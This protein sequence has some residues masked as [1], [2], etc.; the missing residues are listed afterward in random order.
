MDRKASTLA[1]S[2]EG[3]AS[4]S[5]EDVTPL[6]IAYD[7]RQVTPGALFV[8][9]QGAHYDGH[10]FAAEAVR[11]GA[12]LLLCERPLATLSD[13]PQIIVA[14]SR[15][16][17][18]QVAAVF[19]GFP[20]Q[21]MRLIGVTGTNGKTTTTYLI[22]AMLESSGHKTGLIGTMTGSRT[23][24]ESPEIQSLLAGMLAGGCET[25]VME[26][27]S[28]GIDLHRTEG[29]VFSIGLFTNLTQDH[30]D[31]H[32][33]F[34]AYRDA[35]LRLFE[36]LTDVAIVND[37]DPNAPH[38]VAAAAAPVV[39]YGLH[40]READIVADNVRI[41]PTGVTYVARTPA[42]SFDV[43]LSLTG[44]FN[45]YNSLG[46]IAV[47]YHLGIPH[48]RMV[49][50]L[51]QVQVPGRF[52]R[53]D[54]GQP[55]SVIVDYAHTP[56]GLA[57]V[58]RTAREVASGRVIVVFGAG[59]D[60]DPTKRAPMGKAAAERAD[61]LIIT[62]DNPRSEEPQLICRDIEAGVM[63]VGL[64]PKQYD[65]ILPRREAIQQAIALADE[66][67]LVLIAGKGHETY[68]E[69][70]GTRSHF[71]DREEAILALEERFGSAKT[72]TH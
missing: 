69:T 26:V 18:G 17:M 25:C 22:Q 30:L 20:S 43:S 58:L 4:R 72:H 7:S 12:S 40:S 27:S 66:G 47:G 45:V 46:A 60:R 3:E 14:N 32:A 61:Y 71:D 41:L 65:I 29:C 13:T 68:Q 49:D 63:A 59:G 16:A 62:S 28:H 1:A 34:E 9:W 23:T 8:C 70:N 11:K 2:I 44:M 64:S 5:G 10:A 38:F 21:H 6:S 19:N 54:H 50:G 67:D 39:R 37:D 33:T 36:Q 53:I 35:K 24:P 15:K 56:D 55:F 42:A 48:D 57:N 52:Q 31:Y 51:S